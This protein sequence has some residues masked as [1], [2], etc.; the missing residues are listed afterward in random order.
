VILLLLLSLSLLLDAL[1]LWLAR[2]LPV[3]HRSATLNSINLLPGLL[4]FPAFDADNPLMLNLAAYGLVIGHEM[5]HGFDN[6][7]R[8][9]DAI[10]QERDWWTASDKAEFNARSQC[11]I[12]QY[13]SFKLFNHSVDGK[14]TLGENIAESDTHKKGTHTLSHTQRGRATLIDRGRV[15]GLTHVCTRR[16]RGRK[17]GRRLIGWSFPHSRR[18][19]LLSPCVVVAVSRLFGSATAVLVW[20]GVR[21]RIWPRIRPPTSRDSCSTDSQTISCSSSEKKRR[22]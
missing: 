1:A 11:F 20:L 16:E 14:N 13:S 4:K 7:G 10:G 8:L 18:L 15:A 19:R 12:D 5:T 22:Q 9:Y 17:G 6:S 3:P 2:P 21:T